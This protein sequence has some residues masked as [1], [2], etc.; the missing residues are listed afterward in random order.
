MTVGRTKP[1][2]LW[3]SPERWSLVHARSVA[4]GS[5]AQMANVLQMALQDIAALADALNSEINPWIKE[6]PRD[7]PLKF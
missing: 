5:E 7:E 2:I 1:I 6:R 3:N 4:A